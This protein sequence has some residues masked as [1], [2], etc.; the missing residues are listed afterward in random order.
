MATI[1]LRVV[2]GTPLT[3]AEVDSNFS[4][5]ND[6]IISVQGTTPTIAGVTAT[7]AS[8][9]GNV[10]FSI[11]PT[12]TTSLATASASFDLI[13]TG[14]TTVN[15]AKA[16]TTLS[17][18]ATT[19]NTTVNNNLAVTGTTTITGATTVNNNLT[20]TGTVSI[21]STTAVKLPVGTTVQ[22][23][24]GVAGYLRFNT[25]LNK[26]EGYDGTAWGSIGGGATGAVGNSVFYENDTTITA[27]YTISTGKNAM[28]TGP[29]ITSAGVTITV[30][31][32]SRWVVL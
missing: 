22:Q 15:F 19:G 10:V 27:N 3:V 1:V 20:V 31:S 14:A 6:A 13:N 18:G 26:F 30:P 32:G 7:G 17:I 4:N 21:T 28:C 24:T 16:A 11:S 8:G 25:T 2:K 5:I 29:I 12:I 9:T 23:P